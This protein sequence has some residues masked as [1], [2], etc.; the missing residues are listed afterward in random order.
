MSTTSTYGECVGI[1][2]VVMYDLRTIMSHSVY[3]PHISCMSEPVEMEK[4]CGA[5]SYNI[6]LHC[7][8]VHMF[9]QCCIVVSLCPMIHD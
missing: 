4:E 6:N 3:N 7:D 1:T 5:T 9:T 2:R 8:Q